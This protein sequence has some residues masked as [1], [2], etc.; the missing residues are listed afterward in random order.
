MTVPVIRAK[1]VNIAAYILRGFMKGY[2]IANKVTSG[3][4]GIHCNCCNGYY[5]GR[6]MK[7]TKTRINRVVRRNF[8]RDFQME[9]IND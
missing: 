6:S 3:P 1:V 8:K 7:A 9:N 2:H 4:M 5:K